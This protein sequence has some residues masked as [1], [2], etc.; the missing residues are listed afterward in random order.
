MTYD[1]AD[2]LRPSSRT[3]PSMQLHHFTAAIGIDRLVLLRLKEG[4]K[5]RLWDTYNDH[6]AE[7]ICGTMRISIGL[8]ASL[9][10]THW[11]RIGRWLHL[12]RL[13]PI[14][15]RATGLGSAHKVPSDGTAAGP[16]PNCGRSFWEAASM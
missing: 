6:R 4:E 16:E 11:K 5:V 14:S 1:T 9:V 15:A 12:R 7:V 3:D 10:P 13:K 8:G 2:S